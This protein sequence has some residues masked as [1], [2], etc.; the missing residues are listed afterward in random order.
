MT[1]TIDEKE[2]TVPKGTLLIE[3]ARGAGIDIPY[4]CY[5][6]QLTPFG[7]CRLCLVEVEKVPKMLASCNTLVA[8]GMVV[9][10]NTDRVKEQRAGTIEFILLN[11]PLDCPVCDKGGECELQ[12]RVFECGRAESRMTEPKVHVEDYDLGPLIV[13]NQD[14]C[15]I[16]RRCIK[17]ME[18]IDGD[19]VIE[20]GQRGVTT[21]VYT[22]E[23]S[24]FKPGFSGNTIPVC[25]VGALMSKPFRFRARP[26]ELIKTPGICT[27]CSMGCSYRQDTREN[28]L[29][30]VVGLE[31]RKVNDGWLCDRGQFGYDWIHTCNRVR[32][33][34]IRKDGRLEEVSWEE[35]IRYAASRL[36]EMKEKYGAKAIGFLGSDRVSNEDC[37]L[38]QQFAR[39]AVGTANVDHRMGYGRG[40]YARRRPAPGAIEALPDS[41]VVLLAGSDLT[42][43]VP[44]LDL[45]LK[46]S[47]LKG[48]LKLIIVHP[49]RIDLHNR[50]HQWLR[51]LPGAELAA[52]NA[53]VIAVLEQNL[54]DTALMAENRAVMDAMRRGFQ[55]NCL[56]EAARAAGLAE[57][58][59]LAAV[60]T[61][62]GAKRASVL[63]SSRLADTRE[64]AGLVEAL[65]NLA[66]LTGQAARDGHVFME[67]VEQCNT[68][69]ARDL[70][71][72]PDS[73]P[74]Y[75][76]SPA[77]L[78]TPDML[79][80]LT[81]GK[82][83]ALFVQ[84]AN[85][86]IDYPDA[87]LAKRA[88]EGAELLVVQDLFLSETAALADLVLPLA[89]SAEQ[90]ATYTNVEGRV[91]R[92][93]RALDA[94]GAA[95]PGWEALAE[96]AAEMGAPLGHAG[97]KSVEQAIRG[98]LGRSGSP[99]PGQSDRSDTSDRSD[100][101]DTSDSSEPH[102]SALTQVDSPPMAAAPDGFPLRLLTGTVMFNRDTVQREASELPRLAGE[103]DDEHHPET[104]AGVPEGTML[105]VASAKGELRLKLKVSDA[106]PP[107]A[108]FVPAGFN[109]AP[110]T[111]L[112]ND[113]GEP[114]WVRVGPVG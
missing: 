39:Q 114:V 110:V 35:A 101:S 100:R 45:V 3:A 79:R 106:T 103:A 55:G 6:H 92:T 69:G 105:A 88:I 38:L 20:F 60:R 51:C 86:M 16:C 87:D 93:V 25:P 10:T 80:G 8:D 23:H 17:V 11:H 104:A 65:A 85:P 96:I 77:G 1:L 26:W 5:H 62:A 53:L 14:R 107:G 47:L 4:L 34:L 64:G 66:A 13:R 46:R 30:R 89:A 56:A 48:Q 99:P 15:I 36:R 91:Q 41:D 57:E 61:F 59:L 95:R 21:E 12:D 108:A 70:G 94:I 29:L 83:R 111:R 76:K 78:G 84:G 68:W 109:E 44:V 18:E 102:G 98:A 82:L 42:S 19:P 54:A 50:A 40:D 43:E 97:H 112:T 32:A 81:D 7:G 37:F 90:N 73:G 75:G 24:D 74:G 58:D 27:M 71:V 33:P 2:V 31:N 67:T 63:Y 22:F 9:R 52:A 72:L 113:A 49:R 28:R